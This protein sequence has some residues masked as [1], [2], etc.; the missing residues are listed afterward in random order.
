MECEGTPIYS[1]HAEKG[2]IGCMLYGDEW[3]SKAADMMIADYFYEPLNRAVFEALVENDSADQVL[4]FTKMQSNLGETYN[5]SS[6]ALL[7]NECRDLIPSPHNLENYMR[8]VRES[9]QKRSLSE[10]MITAQ[11]ALGEGK[12]YDEIASIVDEHMTSQDTSRED[13]DRDHTG[14]L[15]ELI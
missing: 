9:W 6:V 7:V 13:S 4:L 15:K 2:V 12:G 1:A 5:A 11:K 8:P 3:V 10:A 14:Q